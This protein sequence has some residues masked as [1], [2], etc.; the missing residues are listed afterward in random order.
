MKHFVAVTMVVALF[1]TGAAVPA[2]Y[3]ADKAPRTEQKMS[4]DQ[5]PAPVRA[6]LEKEAKGGTIGD[7]SM[8]TFVD[9]YNAD[10]ANDYGNLVS[11]TEKMLARYFEGRVPE[12]GAAEPIDGELAVVAAEVVRAHESAMEALDL[13]GALAETRR[14]VARANKY[15]DET[16]PWS[17]AK[18]GD[19]R[20]GTVLGSLLEAIRV[21][22]LLLHPALPRATAAVAA[23]LGVELDGGA[24][25][26]LRTW[27]ALTPGAPLGVGE[28]L[29]PRLDR[30]AVLGGD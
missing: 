15:I 7:V 25:T 17:M 11:R 5:V 14:L 26:A 3:A 13:S 12:P 19:P 21:S 18:T 29:F 27:P 24:G 16:A 6:T 8:E 4:L 23:D 9:R 10:L 20:L 30:A 1:A 22:T 2:V 28:I